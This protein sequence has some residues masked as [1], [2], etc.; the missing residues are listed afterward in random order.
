MLENN[1]A[2]AV[3]IGEG[4]GDFVPV[5]DRNAEPD[6]PHSD[7]PQAL[8]ALLRARRTPPE[9]GRRYVYLYDVIYDG[10]VIVARSPDAECDAARALL[11]RGMTGIL[12][13]IDADSGKPR[14]RLN[15]QKAATLTVKEDV[16]R[17]P[18]FA[19]SIQFLAELLADGRMPAEEVKKAAAGHMITMATLRAAREKLKVDIRREG[20][21]PGSVC[22]WSLPSTILARSHP[23][24]GGNAH[25][26][27]LQGS[28]K[29]EEYGGDGASVGPQ[30]S[31]A[32]ADLDDAKVAFEERAATLEYE[33]GLDRQEA[34]AAA[35][36]DDLW[37][38]LPEFLRRY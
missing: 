17:S 24:N 4:S 25:T 26:C 21:G 20:F 2:L 12:T 34:E 16:R 22:Y 7:Q 27:P 11:A 8:T 23:E 36:E 38:E 10:E 14:L 3:G 19:K 31:T 37:P 13:F 30:I 28:S 9:A 32:V 18:Y 35:A 29:Y 1:R 33:A 5:A 6:K 15:G